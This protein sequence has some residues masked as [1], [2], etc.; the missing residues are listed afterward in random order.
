MLDLHVNTIVEVYS[1]EFELRIVC[2]LVWSLLKKVLLRHQR[3]F[4][5]EIIDNVVIWWSSMLLMDTNWSRNKLLAMIKDSLFLI[6]EDT[7]SIDVHLDLPRS[8]VPK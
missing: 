1:T 7:S 5:T 8:K 4:T 6:E 2:N 3:R